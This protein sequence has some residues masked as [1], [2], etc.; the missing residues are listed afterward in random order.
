MS[1][2]GWLF[3]RRQRED[4]LGEEVQAHLRLAAQER[5]EQGETAEQARISAAREFGNVTLVEEVTRDM[6]GLGWLETL[7]QDLRYGAR[8]LRRNPGFTLVAVLSLALGIGANTAIF[9][10]VDSVRMRTLPVSHPQQLTELRLADTKGLRGSVQSGYPVLTNSIWERIRDHQPQAF[11]GMFA[12]AEDDFNTAPAGEV[13]HAQGLWVSGDFFRVLGVQPAIGRVFTGTDDHKGC[14]LPG[15]VVSYSFWQREFGGDRSVI[16]RKITLDYHP[17]VIIGVT[18]ATFTGL[19]VGQSFDVALPL[20][21]Q[22]TLDAYSFLDDGTIWWLSVMARLRPGSSITEA[23]A[24]LSARS[25]GIFEATL[26]KN[27]PS[28]NVKDYLQ[29]KLAAFPAGTGIS[30]L[31]QQYEDPLWILLATAGL[32]LLIACANLANLMLARASAREREIAVRLALGAS[33]SRLIRQLMVESLLIAAV[34]AGL[35]LLLA[36]VLSRFL[37]AFM[38]TQENTLFLDLHPDWRVLG[39]TMGAAVLTCLLFG[40]TP[41]WRATHIAPGA[42]MK[43]GGRGL[44]ATREGFG[45]RRALVATQV[46]LSVTLLVGG[47]LFSHSLHNLMTVNTGFRQDG[48]L[49]VWTDISNRLNL[50]LERRAAFKLNLLERLR[51]IPG[52]DGVADVRFLPL[53]GGATSNAVWTEGSDRSHGIDAN[54]NWVSRDYFKTLETPFLAG[55]DFDTRDAPTSSPVVIVNKTFA[56]KLGLGPNPVGKHFRRE[57][58]PSDPEMDFEIVG[59]V[60]DTKYRDIRKD[61]GPIAYLATSQDTRFTNWWVQILIRSNV[62]VSDLTSRVRQAVAEVNP[63]ISTEFQ[64]FK[65]TIR[66]GLLRERLM[67]TLSGF[68]GFLAALLATI[69]LYGV[70]SYM[71]VQRTNE[72]GIRMTLGADRREIRKLMMSEAALLL[73]WGLGLGIMLALAAGRAARALLFGLQ[74]YDPGTYALA[75]ALL[76]AVAL[77]ASYL[78]AR[79]A[80]RL[81]PMVALRYE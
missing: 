38:S 35:G 44:T 39:F 37:V 40:L 64:M 2:W 27:Y 72:I 75:A 19:D 18:P 81:D 54:F 46:A 57:A 10:L 6:W 24:Q 26:P 8:M 49:I 7:L 69:G 29:F 15:A 12:W 63:E 16:G 47:L 71:V 80:A 33:R 77:A 13:R 4:E 68:F 66:N 50:P 25:T 51:A 11:L 21:S 31:R 9:Q 42:A 70:M 73:A 55:R 59:L 74:P 48:I 45:L 52:V 36:G 56:Q 28:E 32:V 78:P 67:A 41:A 60:A 20:C 34:G 76:A 65:T 30:W 5:I 62:P 53:S 79:Q 23:T 17:V 61:F 22:D 58:T 1:L 3:R 43:A 14:G